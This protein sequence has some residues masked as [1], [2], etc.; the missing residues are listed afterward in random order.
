ML[1][2]FAFTDEGKLYHWTNK[3]WEKFTGG[4]HERPMEFTDA[5]EGR[6]YLSRV[7]LNWPDGTIDRYFGDPNG[8]TFLGSHELAPF[9]MPQ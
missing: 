6:E 8:E 7:K 4:L 2:L 5:K 1:R 9:Q 3:G